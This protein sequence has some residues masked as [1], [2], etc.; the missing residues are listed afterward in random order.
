MAATIARAQG[1][2]KAGY[3]KASEATRLGPGFS[4]AEANTWRTFSTASIRADGSGYVEVRRDG[5]TIHRFEFA[6][7]A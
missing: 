7:E 5:V 2:T 1:F 4:H 6:A 3:A